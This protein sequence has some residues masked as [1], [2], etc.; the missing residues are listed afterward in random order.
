MNFSQIDI[1]ETHIRLTTDLENHNLKKYVFD[2]RTDLKDHIFRN[3]EFS[4]AIEPLNVPDDDLSD[5]VFKMYESSIHADV[6]PMA[7]VAG[8][9]SEL[10][11]DYLIE[12][13]SKYSIVE[14]GGD[15][16]I[17]NDRKVLCGI[18]S[19]NEVS[20]IASHLKLKN[21][22]NHWVS[23]LHLGKLDIP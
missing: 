22:K 4:L 10:S 19:N 23:V 16:A 21:E 13:G 15:I 17:V 5:I 9:I 20:I 14:N 6:G 7:C 8:T 18:Y 2:M 12:R 1:D 11:L 3:N